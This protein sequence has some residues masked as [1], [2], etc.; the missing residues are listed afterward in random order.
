MPPKGKKKNFQSGIVYSDKYLVDIGDHVFPVEKY[1]LIRDKLI[2]TKFIQPVQILEPP[3]ATRD[4][5]LLVHTAEYLDDL[6]Q[7]RL[8]HRTMFSELPLTREIVDAYILSAGGTILAGRSALNEQNNISGKAGIGIHLGGGFHHAFADR[9]EGFCY[10]NDIAVGIRVLQN[11]GK[12]HKAMVVDCDLHQGNGTAHIFQMDDSVFTFSI[13]QENNYPIKQKSDLD[14]G[15]SDAADD[16]LYLTELSRVI[17]QK[18]D[19]FQPD[20]VIYVAGA[21]P[22]KEDQLGGLSLSKKGLKKRDELVIYSALERNIPI[23][24]VLAGGYALRTD[25]TVDIHT[26]TCLIALAGINFEF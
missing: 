18:Y 22:Y 23:V 4:E 12:I 24:I 16:T 10:T 15:L 14:I 13:H 11:E 21:D 7:L 25:D 9:A 3:P 1:R 26:N 5:L 20:L 2:K 17:P 8:T 6:E 19:D